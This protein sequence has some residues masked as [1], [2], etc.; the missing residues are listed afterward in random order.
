M[1]KKFNPYIHS[2]WRDL[3]V[4]SGCVRIDEKITIPIVLGEAPTDDLHAS[5]PGT[6]GMICMATHCCWPYMN[7]KLIVQATKCKPCTAIGKNPKSVIPSNQFH[8]HIPCA[9][10]NQ[11][12]Q[13]KFVRSICDEKGHEICLLAAVDRFSKIPT[14]CIFEKANSLKLFK[15]VDMYL[16]NH[17][18]QLCIRLDQAKCLVEHQVKTSLMRIK[19]KLLKLLSTI[20]KLLV[21]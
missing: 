19:L 10:P 7:K 2:Y 15:I 20:I 4:R 16:E 1:L 11:E 5:H 9:E 18:I 21:W 12:I 3:H 17:V 14:A 13:T 6:S 8:S